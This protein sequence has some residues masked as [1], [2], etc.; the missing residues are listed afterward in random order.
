M[1]YGKDDLVSEHELLLPVIDKI[2]DSLESMNCSMLRREDCQA[3]LSKVMY[4]LT[5]MT[6]VTSHDDEIIKIAKEGIYIGY[7]LHE[8]MSTRQIVKAYIIDIINWYRDR[9][10]GMI[11]DVEALKNSMSADRDSL[12]VLGGFSVV[13]EETSLDDLF[14]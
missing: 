7:S 6:P 13:Y 5:M 10:Q 8:N 3:I 2:S 11:R 12:R 4:L 9:V 14:F 1:N